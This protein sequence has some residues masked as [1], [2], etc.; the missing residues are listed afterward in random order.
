ML[1]ERPGDKAQFI[2]CLHKHERSE[3]DPSTQVK[4]LNVVLFTCDPSTRE[5]GNTWGLLVF[6]SSQIVFQ[7]QKEKTLFENTGKMA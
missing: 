7:V 3:L 1:C 5:G 4:N 6:Q 2:E